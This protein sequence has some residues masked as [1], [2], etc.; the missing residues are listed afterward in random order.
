MFD[1]HG[2]A[3]TAE[4]LQANLLKYIEN[5]RA[6]WGGGAG[7]RCGGCGCLSAE[8]HAPHAQQDAGAALRRGPTAAVAPALSKRHV[9]RAANMQFWEGNNAPE[10]AVTKAF[11]KADAVRRKNPAGASAGGLERF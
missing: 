11:I 1:G 5:V 4:W 6:F 2:G 7:H 10:Q 9:C 8:C 3:A